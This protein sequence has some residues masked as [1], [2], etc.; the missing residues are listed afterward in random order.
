[1]SILNGS[2]GPLTL[3]VRSPEAAKA[4]KQVRENRFELGYASTELKADRDVVLAAVRKSGF[5]LQFASNEF[6]GDKDF[7][8]EAQNACQPD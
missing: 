8:L 6:L 1:M 4:I 5:A 7:M 2:P 3:F